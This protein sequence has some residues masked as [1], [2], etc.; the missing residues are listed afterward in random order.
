MDSRLE[1][2]FISLEQQRKLLLIELGNISVEA[3]NRQRSGKWSISE[4]AGHLIS[5]EQL[6]LGYINKKIN[7]INK[8]GN[9]GIWGEL[10]LW[11]FIIS[12]RLPLKYKAP[13]M[14]GEKPKSYPDM[15][16]LERDWS[17]SREELKGL[18]ERFSGHELKKKI[19]RHPVMGRS[20]ITHTLI[21][22]REH[23]IHHYPQIKRQL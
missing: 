7:A 3:L 15:A 1:K 5:A 20:N 8:V 10:K 18:L 21:F 12:Q 9:T 2:I 6:S 11:A 22:F 17:K 13:K 4:I 16:A 14:L 23:I 19:Y